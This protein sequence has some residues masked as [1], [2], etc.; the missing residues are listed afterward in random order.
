M[1]TR[2][3]RAL[4]RCA[5]LATVAATDSDA[6]LFLTME[7]P[8]IVFG[9]NSECPLAMQAG[10]PPMLLSSCIIQQPSS[11]PAAPPP[12]PA[13]A[14]L[15]ATGLDFS[16]AAIADTAYCWCAARTRPRALQPTCTLG[17]SEVAAP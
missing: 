2:R 10:D 7:N 5:L 11:P 4:A 1:G 13:Q 3:M 14:H 6:G 8:Q 9:P 17:L 15:I 16:C 12:A